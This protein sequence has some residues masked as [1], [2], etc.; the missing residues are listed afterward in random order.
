MEPITIDISLVVTVVALATALLGVLW[1]MHL[2]VGRFEKL[3]KRSDKSK[4]VDV[5]ILNALLACLEG[6]KQQGCNGT[7]TQTLTNLKDYIVK[8]R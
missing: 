7:V 1:R 5:E 8:S 6:L 2:L 3:E 4:E